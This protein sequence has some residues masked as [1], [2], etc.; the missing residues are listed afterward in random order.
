M[1]TAWRPTIPTE[2]PPPVSTAVPYRFGDVVAVWFKPG[3]I[4]IDGKPAQCLIKS[5]VMMP[6][7][8]TT[9]PHRNHPKSDVRSLVMLGAKD[10]PG[11]MLPVRCE[12]VLAIHKCIGPLPREA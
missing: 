11:M 6:S 4:T 1:E 10:Q 3:V 2:P 12:H 7:H 5:I 9:F 8:G